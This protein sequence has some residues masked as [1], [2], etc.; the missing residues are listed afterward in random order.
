M[1]FELALRGLVSALVLTA[2][3]YV[4][5]IKANSQ[6]W[7]WLTFAGLAVWFIAAV[8]FACTAI[9]VWQP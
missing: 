8:V 7:R 5:N 4:M 9:W 3:F 2:A 6:P 1:T